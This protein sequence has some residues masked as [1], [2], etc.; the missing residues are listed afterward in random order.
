[1]I[2][3]CTGFRPLG[4]P[5]VE[6]SLARFARQLWLSGDKKR[7]QLVRSLLA[8]RITLALA[9]EILSCFIASASRE[10]PLKS[11]S[12]N[13]LGDQP[14]GALDGGFP[15]R[16][17]KPGPRGLPRAARVVSLTGFVWS[18]GD[19]PRTHRRAG[20]GVMPSCIG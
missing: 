12:G 19:R 14:H 4:A 8:S 13:G 10:R 7:D 9:L 5:Y 15:E 2:M 3:S 18:N 1:M 16:G 20:A 6:R 11:G 17:L